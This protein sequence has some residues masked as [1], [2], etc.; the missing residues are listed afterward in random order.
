MT[1]EI[2]R[3]KD[4]LPPRFTV[5]R[6]ATP[7]RPPSFR[8]PG[9]LPLRSRQ[10]RDPQSEQSVPDSQVLKVDATPCS[11]KSGRAVLGEKP[12]SQSPSSAVPQVSEHTA[13][14]PQSAQSVP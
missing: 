9:N 10:Y 13:R 3:M 6:L 1:P 5:Y 8:E 4:T 11:L 7:A 2:V 12:S 14:G